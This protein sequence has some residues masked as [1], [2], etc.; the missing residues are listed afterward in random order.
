MS[1]AQ[2]RAKSGAP[3]ATRGDRG[4]E[5]TKGVAPTGRNAAGIVGAGDKN[6]IRAPARI[7]AAGATGDQGVGCAAQQGMGPGWQ[8][9]RAAWRA[10]DDGVDAGRSGAP[11]SRR[12]QRM[13]HTVFMALGVTSAGIPTDQ[14]LAFAS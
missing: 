14:F 4:R 13:V 3:S 9:A 2:S 7:G 6:W 12:P 1:R 5:E 8:Q 11:A 10:H